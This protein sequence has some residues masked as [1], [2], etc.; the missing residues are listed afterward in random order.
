MP[1]K[2][3]QL[4]NSIMLHLSARAF[5]LSY[6]F[7]FKPF[8]FAVFEGLDP[9]M[10][11]LSWTCNPHKDISTPCLCMQVKSVGLHCGYCKL[12]NP[13]LQ[14][15]PKLHDGKMWPMY[16]TNFLS[17]WWSSTWGRTEPGLGFRLPLQSLHLQVFL[18]SG[19][20]RSQLLLPS[21][22]AKLS[23]EVIPFRCLQ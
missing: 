11:P 23:T 20:E 8:F 14:L 7:P 13:T 21:P 17:S 19:Q 10:F 12:K 5:P 15:P 9:T 4:S 1:W 18:W 3:E 6:H 16:S 2:S 22:R